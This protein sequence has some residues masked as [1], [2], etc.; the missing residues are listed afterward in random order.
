[1]IYRMKYKIKFAIQVKCR[2][3]VVYGSDLN[4]IQLVQYTHTKL[5]Y[6]KPTELPVTSP[7]SPMP[8][9]IKERDQFLHKQQHSCLQGSACTISSHI[10]FGTIIN[11]YIFSLKVK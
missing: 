8:P 1:M 9:H 4:Y 3:V 11:I 10:H 6:I 2:T 7:S 5:E